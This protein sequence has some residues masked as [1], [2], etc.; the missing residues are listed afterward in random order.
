MEK[1]RS[2]VIAFFKKD[3]IFIITMGAVALA[4]GIHAYLDIALTVVLFALLLI[5]VKTNKLF[6]AYFALIFFEPVLVVPIV[7][8]TFFR[9]FYLLFFIRLIIDIIAKAKY[10]WDIPTI[11]LAVLLA[12]TA[13][14]YSISVSRLFSVV[15]NILVV[16][17]IMLS[18]KRQENKSAAFGELLT[19]IAVFAA[20]SGIYGLLQGNVND[21]ADFVRLYGTISD[22]NYSAMFY[23]IGLFA[24]FGA[25]MIKNTWGRV[26]LS[27][28][29]V[30]L[31]ITTVSITGLA[32]AGFLI[33]L[34]LFFSGRAKPALIVILVGA[35]LITA[36]FVI[37]FNGGGVL[38]GTQEK[39]NRFLVFDDPYPEFRYQYPN[40]SDLELYI[41]R[42]TSGRY[43]LSKTYAIHLFINTPLSQQ[44][45]GGNNPVEGGFRELVPVRYGL[46]SHN[47]YI[48]MFFMMGMIGTAIM[49][50]LILIKLIRYYI[51]YKKSDDIAFLCIA[52]ITLTVLMFCMSISIFP[53]RY[54][55]AYLL[56]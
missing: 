46:V 17:Y 39:L 41:N 32:F 4:Y 9:L 11:I 21:K 5:N 42:I 51:D 34:F 55:I 6:Y 49:L 22:S 37:P 52:F 40:Y 35:I 20:L 3:W 53:Y 13:V 33:L 2:S 26:A 27:A 12:V 23:I 30:L 56:I 25:T 24:S 1:P 7:G 28:F 19:Y 48:D 14:F 36:L 8:G 18:L 43:Y 54:T 16:T 44:L 31:L 10:Q 45:F 38:E 29:L 15:M 47:S 50:I